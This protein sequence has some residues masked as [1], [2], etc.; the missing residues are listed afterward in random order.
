MADPAAESAADP[1]VHGADP[2]AA[3][4]PVR[5]ASTVMLVRDGRRGLEVFTLHR[6]PTMVFAPGV[7]VF[8]GGGVDLADADPAVPWSG[9]GPDWWAGQ[10]RLDAGQARAAVV[11]AVRELF[12]ETGVLLAGDGQIVAAGDPEREAAR[13]AIASRRTALAAVLRGWDAPVRADRLYPWGRWITPVGPPRRYDTFFF[14]AALPAGA[15]ARS[16]TTE[17]VSGAW[18]RPGDV[19]TAAAAGSVGLMPPTI[20]MLEELAG[21]ATVAAVTAVPRVVEPVVPEVLAADGEV[22]RVRVAGREYVTPLRY[23]RRT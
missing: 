11:A 2:A 6:A 3:S 17:A 9:P 4:V 7:T 18:F 19:L 8:P 1:A 22:L 10:L 21:F 12:E 5:H 23:D 16:V 13:T 15:D 14:L 20:A